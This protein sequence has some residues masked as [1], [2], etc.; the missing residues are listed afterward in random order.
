M[1]GEGGDGRVWGGGKGG[2]C[3]CHLSLSTLSATSVP[4][5]RTLLLLFYSNNIQQ[6]TMYVRLLLLYGR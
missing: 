3:H 5:Y 1:S 6:L 2:H 4:T